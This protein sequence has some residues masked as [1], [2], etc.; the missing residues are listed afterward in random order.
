MPERNP[1]ILI[2][3]ALTECQVYI[4]ERS[5]FFLINNGAGKMEYTHAKEWSR[6]VC[7]YH[8]LI[9]KSTNSLWIKSKYATLVTVNKP[10]SR[11]YGGKVYNTAFS[12]NFLH[13]I[14]KWKRIKPKYM[15]EL[16][17]T[18]KYLHV[19]EN[20]WQWRGHLQ[21]ERTYVQT[22]DLLRCSYQVCVMINLKT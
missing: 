5:C 16:H 21:K 3:W 11:N 17:T 22:T 9:Q 4:M 7:L 12:T 2:K 18:E 13:V 19:K 14:S 10:S 1:H 6:T 15:N 8:F 20:N